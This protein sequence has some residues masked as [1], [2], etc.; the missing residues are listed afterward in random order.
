MMNDRKNLTYEEQYKYIYEN[1]QIFVTPFDVTFCNL[2]IFN[3]YYSIIA[4]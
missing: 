3:Y 4:I 1:Q 2:D